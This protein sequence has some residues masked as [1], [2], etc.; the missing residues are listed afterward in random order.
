M[1]FRPDMISF[2]KRTL[3]SVRIAIFNRNSEVIFPSQPKMKLFVIYYLFIMNYNINIFFF[4][5]SKIHLNLNK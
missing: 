1:T 4:F 3:L 2:I 5:F